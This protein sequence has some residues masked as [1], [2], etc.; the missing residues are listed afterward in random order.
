MSV[1]FIII[2]PNSVGGHSFFVSFDTLFVC[3]SVSPFSQP[4]VNPETVTLSY[5]PRYGQPPK[6]IK[7]EVN[8]GMLI[9]L[10]SLM[11]KLLKLPISG[12]SPGGD[13]CFSH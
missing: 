12:S 11:S 4:C 5:L 7:F 9:R 3:L 13:A 10:I 6:P 8:Q 2:V 1:S